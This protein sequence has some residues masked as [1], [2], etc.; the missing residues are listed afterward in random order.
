MVVHPYVISRDFPRV[1]YMMLPCS[2]NPPRLNLQ[3]VRLLL[4]A[5]GPTTGS[6]QFTHPNLKLKWDLLKLEVCRVQYTHVSMY[7]YICMS[8]WDWTDVTFLIH[9]DFWPFNHGNS[10]PDW[11]CLARLDSFWS[12]VRSQNGRDCV[13]DSAPPFVRSSRTGFAVVANGKK[14]SG[15]RSRWS[16]QCVNA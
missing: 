11:E 9:F 2:T 5:F 15:E 12:D 8:I 10:T 4:V 7:M 3:A 13:T 6:V 1:Y 16:W 14:I